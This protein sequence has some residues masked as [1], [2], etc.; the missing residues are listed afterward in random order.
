MRIDA[1][2]LSR[3]FV[4][5]VVA[6]MAQLGVGT[7]TLGGNEPIFTNGLAVE[8]SQLAYILES[9]FDAQIRV[10]LVTSGPSATILARVAPEAFD[11]LDMVFVSLDAP[12]A[13]R[14]NVNR[15]AKLFDH[16]MRALQIARRRGV[17]RSLL[18]CA[19]RG[20]F[21]SA[22]MNDLVTLAKK[23]ESRVRVNT[24]KPTGR[25]LADRALDP[26]SY[27]IGFSRLNELCRTDLVD[28]PTLRALLG[29]DTTSG[30]PCGATTFRV[31]HAK[32]D[33]SVPIA[34]C[35]YVEG[36]R[37]GD[38]RHNSLDDIL[39]SQE[40]QAFRFRAVSG[41]GDRNAYHGSECIA[42]ATLGEHPQGVDPMSVLVDSRR[43]LPVADVEEDSDLR[44]RFGGYL[45]TWMG[46]PR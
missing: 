17:D 34:P 3:T 15:G 25:A 4:D 12:E 26:E 7:V 40:F 20:N 35:L 22:D 44:D 6:Q 1:E 37:F 36:A 46:T 23:T 2:H 9:L 19:R 41:E 28:E 14:H 11:R 45:C 24:L 29:L 21:S 31:S 42:Q 33:G 8:D 43:R 16:A 30:C 18:Y 32:S 39:G 10:A 27:M 13:E 5:R 38:L